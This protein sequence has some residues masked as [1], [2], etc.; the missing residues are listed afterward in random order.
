MA[1]RPDTLAQTEKQSKSRLQ[2]GR[3]IRFFEPCPDAAGPDMLAAIDAMDEA[4][5]QMA[6]AKRRG[7]LQ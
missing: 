1:P 2:A 5:A 4:V 3:A 7:P 6:V